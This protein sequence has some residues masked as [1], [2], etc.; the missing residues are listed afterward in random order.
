M[1]RLYNYSISQQLQVCKSWHEIQCWMFAAEIMCMNMFLSISDTFVLQFEP[2]ERSAP[3]PEP[4]K[5][6]TS[7][8]IDASQ[9][10]GIR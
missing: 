10:I 2:H 8:H 3:P 7:K 5:I 4:S 6:D 1:Y 9:H